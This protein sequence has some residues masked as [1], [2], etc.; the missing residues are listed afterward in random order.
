[1]IAADPRK[2]KY[3][4]ASAIFRGKVASKEVEAAMAAVQA[5]NKVCFTFKETTT[6]LEGLLC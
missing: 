1:M 2:G 4:T 3:L 5:K 6:N